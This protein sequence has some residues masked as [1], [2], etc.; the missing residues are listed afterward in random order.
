MDFKGSVTK[1]KSVVLRFSLALGGVDQKIRPNSSRGQVGV[2]VAVAT[3]IRRQVDDQAIARWLRQQ[4]DSEYN[5]AKPQERAQRRELRDW[6]KRPGAGI[7]STQT[8]AI[9]L[10]AELVNAARTNQPAEL[11][12]ASD[13]IWSIKDKTGLYKLFEAMVSVVTMILG[14]ALAN[15]PRVTLTVKP[16]PQSKQRKHYPVLLKRPR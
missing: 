12:L 8:L 2:S 10:A 11:V 1:F 14:S 13:K 5:S 15:V 7:P 3:E 16:S 9:A 4:A 6:T